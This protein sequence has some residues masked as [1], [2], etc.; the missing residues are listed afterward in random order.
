[1]KEIKK[2]IKK[3]MWN[4][5]I[6]WKNFGWDWE[7]PACKKCIDYFEDKDSKSCRH[8]DKKL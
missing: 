3:K 2:K 5:D 1:M 6:C 8:S 4:E 7:N